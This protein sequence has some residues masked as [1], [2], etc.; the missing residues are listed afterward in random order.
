MKR[1]LK[2]FLL[3]GVMGMGPGLLVV[4]PST[5]SAVQRRTPPAEIRVWVNTPTGVYHCPGTRWYGATKKGEYMT[6]AQ[7]VA[8]GHRA[9]YGKA[10]Q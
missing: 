8:A 9:A 6:Q 2:F 7:A 10:C 3:F 5:A 1:L 4:A